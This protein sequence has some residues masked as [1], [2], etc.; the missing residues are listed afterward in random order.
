MPFNQRTIHF[1]GLKRTGQH[2]LIEWIANHFEGLVGLTNN[3]QTIPVKT[4]KVTHYFNVDD[5]VAIEKMR[6]QEHYGAEIDKELLFITYEDFYRKVN[7]LLEAKEQIEMTDRTGITGEHGVV[8]YVVCIRDFYNNMASRM[9]MTRSR[10]PT[11]VAPH[12][13]SQNAQEYWKRLAREFGRK[14]FIWMNF[15][16]WMEHPVYRRALER[17]LGLD[18]KLADRAD[19]HAKST[20]AHKT[21]G[22]HGSSFDKFK[23][24]R[25][26][27]ARYLEMLDDPEYRDKVL[28]DNDARELNMLL[29]GWTLS[30]QGAII[31]ERLR[32]AKADKGG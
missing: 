16:A 23:Q 31:D 21:Y 3:V 29:F 1:F 10:L 27:N 11:T 15:N 2:A 32:T 4:F 30:P 6:A 26:Q 25:Q 19:S 28:S 8:Q 18:T 22:G 24:T 9:K 5:P 13:Y 20:V 14:D 17:E 7:N 12:G